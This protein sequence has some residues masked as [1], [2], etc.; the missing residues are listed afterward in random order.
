[1]S[2]SSGAVCWGSVTRKQAPP[3][4]L[5]ERGNSAPVY[6]H[7]RPTHCES[8]GSRC[9][10]FI[11]AINSSNIVCSWP[12]G[13]PGPLS[14]TSSCRFC[15]QRGHRYQFRPAHPHISPRSPADQSA[16]VQRVARQRGL[17]S[18]V[19]A[20]K[21]RWVMINPVPAFAARCRPLLPALTNFFKLKPPD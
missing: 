1:M 17:R 11:P 14:Q 8:K 7:Y 3:S 6:I 9:R 18:A 16:P 19:L 5:V 2:F 10:L 12:G 13:R 20:E 21:D 4:W 15:P